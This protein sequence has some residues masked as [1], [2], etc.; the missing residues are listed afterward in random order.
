MSS[1]SRARGEG[2]LTT[3]RPTVLALDV[4]ASTIKAAIVDVDGTRLQETTVPTGR[5]KGGQAALRTVEEAAAGLL[6]HPGTDV[7]A[8]GVAMPGAVGPDGR[9]TSVNLSLDRAKVVAPLVQRL[10]VPVR[11][12]N[13]AQAGA[14]G[15][16][17]FGVAVSMNDFFYVSLGTGIGGA[18]VHHGALWSGANGQ[19]GEL[20]H[21]RVEYPG[22]PC[23][24]GASGCLQTIMSA[25]ALEARWA[26]AEGTRLDA[27]SIIALA[28]SNVGPARPLWR[29]AVHGLAR[30]L[31]QATTLLDPGTI[32]IGGGLAGAGDTLLVPLRDQL[33]QQA[34]PFHVVAPL[35]LASLGPWSGCMGAASAAWE[36]ASPTSGK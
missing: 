29:A 14:L 24:R 11:I 6:G 9:V 28:E 16:A 33:D 21:V 22:R 23:A 15:E 3:R 10:N 4:G 27:R 5:E 2:A 32:V 8:A 12:L 13:D 36:I 20:G 17:R 34:R 7:R 18:I 35:R 31:L 1:L 26:E 25:A 30:G 19:A